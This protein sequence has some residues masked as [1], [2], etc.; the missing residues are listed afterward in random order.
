MP[1]YGRH[2]TSAE[3]DFGIVGDGVQRASVYEVM[4]AN[5]WGHTVGLFC[6]KQSGTPSVELGV[7]K[8]DSSMNPAGRMGYGVAFSPSTAMADIAGGAVYEAAFGAVD[9]EFSPGDGSPAAIN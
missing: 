5:G 6:G 3:S 2:V 9:L 1:F 7:W 4:P 8:A